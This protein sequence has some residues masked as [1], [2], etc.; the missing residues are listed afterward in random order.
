MTS[1]LYSVAGFI[2]KS[3]FENDLLDMLES[4]YLLQI[5]AFER[6]NPGNELIPACFG[7]IIHCRSIGFVYLV[8]VPEEIKQTGIHAWT[9]W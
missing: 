5:A 1:F 4:S 9:A 3:I 6:F 8:S 7:N 2:S